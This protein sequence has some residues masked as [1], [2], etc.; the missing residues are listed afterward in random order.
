ME[1]NVQLQERLGYQLVSAQAVPDMRLQ[2]AVP[3][4]GIRPQMLV[5]RLINQAD[6]VSRVMQR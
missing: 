1:D 5:N 3:L 4:L 6:G 2:D